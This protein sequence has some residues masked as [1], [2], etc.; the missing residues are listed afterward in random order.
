MQQFESLSVIILS[1]DDYVLILNAESG[2]EM[3]HF[4]LNTKYVKT[5]PSDD[6]FYDDDMARMYQSF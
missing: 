1:L 2:R 3:G 5:F 6:L 4:H